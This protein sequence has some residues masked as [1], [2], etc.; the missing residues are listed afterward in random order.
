MKLVSA[1][2]PL[3]F[4]ALRAISKKLSIFVWSTD[5]YNW[6]TVVRP[7]DLKTQGHKPA[8]PALF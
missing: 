3:V 8:T 5:S 1:Y 7:S 6:N 2:S 4:R